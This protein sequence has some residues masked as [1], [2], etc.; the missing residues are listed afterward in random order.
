MYIYIYTF[1]YICI[2]IHIHVFISQQCKCRSHQSQPN[3]KRTFQIE[4]TATYYK[5][6]QGTATHCNTLQHTATHC[7]AHTHLHFDARTLAH[8]K[9]S[10]NIPKAKH[11]WKHIVTRTQPNRALWHNF[12]LDVQTRGK[13]RYLLKIKRGHIS[14]NTCRYE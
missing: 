10:E 4:S 6:H 8:E 13:C 1:V 9:T 2:C 12:H 7:N 14:N 3:N 11:N 5:T